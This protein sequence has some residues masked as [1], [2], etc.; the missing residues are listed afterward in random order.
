MAGFKTISVPPNPSA[1]RGSRNSAA[2]SDVAVVDDDEA[3]VAR[4]PVARTRAHPAH[5]FR[6]GDRLNMSP[7]GHSIGRA[8]SI[9]KVLATLPYEG[10]GALLYRVRSERETFDRVVAEADLS[11]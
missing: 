1:R 10:Y 8:G 7:G 4:R 5:R 6:I 9:C 11:R 3:I 2:A